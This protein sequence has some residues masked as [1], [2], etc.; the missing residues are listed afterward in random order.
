MTSSVD[1][2]AKDFEVPRALQLVCFGL[3]VANIVYVAASWYFGQWLTD[4][5][6]V[7]VPVDFTNIWAAGRIVNEGHP[8]LAYDPAVLKELEYT[9]SGHEYS[10]Q[11]GWHYPPTFLFVAAA[12]ATLPYAWAFFLWCMLTLLPYLA[13]MRLLVGDRFGWLIAGACPAALS[14]MMIGQ[15]GFLTATLMAGTVGLME[16]QPALAGICLGCLTYKPQFGILFPIVLIAGAQWRTMVFAA[17]STVMMAGA[18]WLAFGSETWLAF[19]HGLPIASQTVLTDGLAGW[20]KLQSIYGVTRILGGGDELAWT[21]QLL[22][23]A[24]VAVALCVIWR[25][26][27]A[28][29]MKTAALVTGVLLV[30]PYVYIYDQVML[31]IPAALLIRTGLNE[32]FRRHELL[33]IGLAAVILFAFPVIVNSSGLAATLIIG[34]LV[35]RRCDRQCGEQRLASVAPFAAH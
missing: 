3:C 35:A 10:A 23:C 17:G 4:L 34:A 6:E 13:A 31:V 30:T 19:L 14:N 15:N 1:R 2:P 8:A 18:S 32:G 22:L 33:G 24:A 26:R 11:F 7:G 25:G 20:S 27:A 5:H 9:F 28:F 12:L 21:L 29:E 16:R